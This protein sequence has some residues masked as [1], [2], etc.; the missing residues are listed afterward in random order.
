MKSKTKTL[1]IVATSFI[2]LGLI[3]FSIVMCTYNWDFTKL[4]TTKFQT[5]KHVISDEFTS[6][7]INSNTA[8]ITILPS[9]DGQNKVICFEDEKE[10][11]AVSVSNGKL[12]INQTNQK[13]WYD[14]IGINFNNTTITIYLNKTQYSLLKINDDTGD[15]NISKD[16]IFNSIDVQVSTGDVKCFASVEESIKIYTSTGDI[17]VENVS[18]KSLELSVS[19]GEI[20][21]STITCQG[22]VNIKSNTGKTKLNGVNCNSFIATADTGDITLT[23]VIARNNLQIE[24]DTGDVYLERS[25]ASEI[26]IETDTGDVRGSLL[27]SKVFI[28]NTDTGRVSVPQTTSGGKCLIE[29]DTGDIIITIV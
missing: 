22:D 26:Q 7:E 27:T 29:T 18:A 21:A 3:I 8:D 19:T 14:Y 5:N 23:D 15:V 9:D 11:N 25:D 28:A 20:T 17:L 16:F 2:V 6:I 13:K 1:L 10:P 12:T 24:L 4:S